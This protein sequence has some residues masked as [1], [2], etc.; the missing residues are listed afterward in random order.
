M[1]LDAFTLSRV[2]RD[3]L[4]PA[5]RR[6]GEAG[7][8][9]ER[10]QIRAQAME[11]GQGVPEAAPPASGGQAAGVGAAEVTRSRDG[12]LARKAS[13]IRSV[14]DRGE[15]RPTAHSIFDG[16]EVTSVIGARAVAAHEPGA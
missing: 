8:Y 10:P 14:G 16:T 11:H 5:V 4:L 15:P 9:D 13:P 6:G 3:G 12:L 1:P 7:P 2:P